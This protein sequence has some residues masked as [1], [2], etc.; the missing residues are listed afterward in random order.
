MTDELRSCPFCGH[1]RLEV[2][3]VPIPSITSL[4]EGY[5]AIDGRWTGDWRTKTCDRFTESTSPT[6]LH[7]SRSVR[8]MKEGLH[9]W[10][11]TKEPVQTSL[12]GW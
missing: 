7:P 9:H 2:S 12:E 11:I 6:R 10:S 8:M 1:I 4:Y 3:M 5:C